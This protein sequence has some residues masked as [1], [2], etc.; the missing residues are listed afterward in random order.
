[1]DPITG[2]ILMV[3]SIGMQFLTN[4]ANN[5][6]AQDLAEKQ[7]KLKDLLDRQR[8]EHSQEMQEEINR[9]QADLELGIHKLR[10]DEIEKTPDD[11]VSKLAKHQDID[12]WPIKVLP[13]VIKGQSFGTLIGGGA[14]TISVHCFLTPSNNLDFNKNVYTDLDIRLQSEINANWSTRSTHPV[15]YYGGSWIDRNADINHITNCIQQLEASLKSI[16]CIIITPKF[17]KDGVKFCIRI[18]GMGESGHQDYEFIFNNI[19]GPEAPNNIRFSYNYS[20]NNKFSKKDFE[21]ITDPDQAQIQVDDFID[22]TINEFSTYLQIL[23][24]YI[25][26]NYFWNIY[27]TSPVLPTMISNKTIQTDG[28]NWIVSGVKKLYFNKVKK[29]LDYETG[30]CSL[31]RPSRFSNLYFSTLSLWDTYQDMG[32]ITRVFNDYVSHQLLDAHFILDKALAQFRLIESNCNNFNKYEQ[33]SLSSLIRDF[34]VKNIRINDECENDPTVSISR[35]NLLDDISFF[36][37]DLIVSVLNNNSSTVFFNYRQIIDYNSAKLELTKLCYD[38]LNKNIF[39]NTPVFLSDLSELNNHNSSLRR[40]IEHCEKGCFRILL[41][42]EYQSGKTTL[43]NALC[44]R[45]IGPMGKGI[46]TSAVPIEVSYGKKDQVI[47]NWKSKEDLLLILRH[48]DPFLVDYDFQKFKFDNKESRDALLN[49]ISDFRKSEGFKACSGKELKF[50]AICSLILRYYDSPEIAEF[51]RK[52]INIHEVIQYTSFPNSSNKLQN[53]GEFESR[54]VKYGYGDFSF[55]ESV[56]CFIDHVEVYC[57]SDKLKEINCTIVDCPGLSASAYDTSITEAEMIKA[58]AILYLTRYDKAIGINDSEVLYRIKDSFPDFSR[59]LIVLNNYKSDTDFNITNKNKVANLFGEHTLFIPI[60]VL[61]AS[62]G[63]FKYSY[64]KGYLTKGEIDLF[65]DIHKPVAS[66]FSTKVQVVSGFEDCWLKK[67]KK[68]CGDEVNLDVVLEELQEVYDKL[69]LFVENNSSYSIILSNGIYKL[70]QELSIIENRVQPYVETFLEGREA[71]Q[72]KWEARMEIAHE[73][74]TAISELAEK[75]IFNTRNDGHS[76][77]DHLLDVVYAD[78]FSKNT[79]DNIFENIC[80][81]I[82]ENKFEIVKL[83]SSKEKLSGF[84]KPKIQKCISRIIENKVEGW[85][86]LMISD[87][88]Q[89][90]G[91]IFSPEMRNFGNKLERLWSERFGNDSLM[92]NSLFEYFTLPISP[93]DVTLRSFP[94]N[95]N[96]NVDAKS[97]VKLILQELGSSIASIAMLISSYICFV[98]LSVFAGSGIVLMN[99]VTAA[100]AMIV[101]LAGGIGIMCSQDKIRKAFYDKMTSKIKDEFEKNG[102]YA[103]IKNSLSSVFENMMKTFIGT[104]SM[105]FSAMENARD[106]SLNSS[107]E[108]IEKNCFEAIEFV[109]NIHRQKK[110]YLDFINKF[111]E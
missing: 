62:L 8:I 60:D 81:I 63:S 56:F 16:P 110:V 17:I 12:S 76:L 77:F 58:D 70:Y 92:K 80:D 4:D 68:L 100:I 86:Q 28:L 94:T 11:I 29:T 91:N 7:R 38:E 18:W 37:K 93:K 109:D 57:L 107:N 90:F 51:K 71:S 36:Q 50:F 95:D 23:I 84:F 46:A 1:M 13:F 79:Y 43:M 34:I 41:M 74:N 72:N 25:T 105:N 24:G 96:V 106:V 33:L 99:P 104:M 40:V 85:N 52:N 15:Y 89:S 21:T 30:S 9:I 61:V 26:D 103:Q 53:D 87:Q 32:D 82:Y 101:L 14:K 3:S 98:I 2:L 49:A 78:I 83:A 97:V 35:K 19:D 64:D 10:M 88:A 5:E 111:K 47:L 65:L 31:I 42:A 55:S 22:T 20:N 69:R 75:H 108:Q 54:W 39:R 67:I 102:I 44:G 45:I 48:V 59:K 6:Q 73:F 27:G 66:R